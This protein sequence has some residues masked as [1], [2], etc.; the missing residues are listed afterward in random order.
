MDHFAY[1]SRSLYCENIPVAQLAERYGTPLYIYSKATLVHHLHQ[2][3]EAF[4]EVEPLICY[5]VKTNGNVALCNV[6]A[7]HGSGFDV[8]SGG[9]LHR[10]LLAGGKG[11]KIVFAGV[12]NSAMPLIIMSR[13]LMLKVSR[14]CMPWAMLQNQWG[15]SHLSH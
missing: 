14:N 2:I 8:T 6:M 7:E 11:E 9:E 12:G 3:Q 15:R 4:K 5:S 1:R 10:A 13:F